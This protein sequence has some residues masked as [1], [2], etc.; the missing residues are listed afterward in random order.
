MSANLEWL[1]IQTPD[2]ERVAVALRCIHVESG[3]ADLRLFGSGFDVLV[4]EPIDGW[5]LAQTVSAWSRDRLADLSHEL[6]CIVQHFVAS[7]TCD[8][9]GWT[10]CDR[11]RVT[12]LISCAE[13]TTVDGARTAA[14]RALGL[15]PFDPDAVPEGVDDDA[16]E[17]DTVEPGFDDVVALASKWSVDPARAFADDVRAVLGR[18]R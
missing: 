5:V 3:R 11:G 1:A 10:W 15:A 7:E 2:P 9:F 8:T 12:R 14:E 6:A 16:A 4:T 13:T 17:D 18:R